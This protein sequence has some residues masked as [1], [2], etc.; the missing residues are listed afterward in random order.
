MK[1]ILI[2]GG[3]GLVG[4]RLSKL[5]LQKGYHIA[6][7]SR[8]GGVTTEGINK[9]E[10]NLK[11]KTI[12]KAAIDWCDSIINL[13]GSNVGEGRWTKNRK[14]EIYD[15][16]IESV[17]L[18]LKSCEL[19]NKKLTTFVS[20]SA[21]GIY[22]FNDSD[23]F[24]DENSDFAND[25]L[26]KVTK[27]WEAEMDKFTKQTERIIKL[28]IGVVLAKE[29]GALPKIIKP[30]QMCAGAPLGNGNQMMSWIHINDLCKLFIESLENETY[31]G[32]YNAV[33]PIPVS[34]KEFTKSVA[35]LLN[36]PLFLPN[37]PSFVLKT[38]LGEMSLIAIKGSNVSAQKLMNQGFNFDFENHESALKDI[39][40]SK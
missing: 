31:T 34:N 23:E 38:L 12:D 27:D 14:K 8:N 36:K 22:G 40:I 17:K 33:A 29:G 10:W 24:F 19:Y 32:A 37:V 2:T 13:A 7:L 39:L 20:A 21:I 28:R 9:F 1:N 18:L 6:F 11:T 16:R 35:K 15:S 3:T 25:F 26:A 30:I 4:K 5:L